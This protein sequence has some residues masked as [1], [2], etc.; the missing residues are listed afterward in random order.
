VETGAERRLVMPVQGTFPLQKAARGFRLARQG[1]GK[2][3]FC[4]RE[5]RVRYDVTI[6]SRLF[7]T[8]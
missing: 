7:H 6:A 4:P 3:Y 5:Y 1:G 8:A 2:A